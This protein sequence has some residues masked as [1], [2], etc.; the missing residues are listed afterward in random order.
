MTKSGLDKSGWNRKRSLI[1]AERRPA[2]TEAARALG[3]LVARRVAQQAPKDTG[4]FAIS[5]G[6]AHNDLSLSATMPL[7]PLKES[8]HLDARIGILVSQKRK[9]EAQVERWERNVASYRFRRQLSTPSGREAQKYLRQWKK[10]LEQATAELDKIEDRTDVESIIVIGGRV[11]K[12]A[13]AGGPKRG[14]A[15]VTIRTFGGQGRVIDGHGATFAEIRSREPHAQLVNRRTRVLSKNIA[16]ARAGGAQVASA[17]YLARI[18]AA[19]QKAG[20]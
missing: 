19:A 14:V 12:R 10:Q 4:R 6:Q 7:P 5:F 8:K 1:E 15:R 20:R 17:K 3:A 11:R 9:A 18:G 2:R 16:L 13:G